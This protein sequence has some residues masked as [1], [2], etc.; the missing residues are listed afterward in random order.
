M[1]ENQLVKVAIKT[2]NDLKLFLFKNYM[3]QIENFFGDNRKAL[4]FLSS[5]MSAVQKVPE[6]LN[7]EGATLVNAFMTMA[8]LGLMPSDVSGE[9]YVLPYAGKAQFQLGYQGLITLFYRAGGQSIRADIV[10]KNDK[11]S[12]ENGQIKH[13]IDI[14]QS[15]KERG[16]AIGAYA[17]ATVGNQEIAKAMN[18]VDII[19]IG[20]K[21]SKSYNTKYTPWKEEN[22]PELMMWKKTV[23]KQLGKLLPKNETINRAIALDNQDSVIADRLKP[24]L[25]ASES[26]KMG[27]LVKENNQ[28]E[29]TAAEN[30]KDDFVAEVEELQKKS[31]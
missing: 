15:N 17:I 9:A 19:N 7:C 30:P 12:Y 10:R 24:A 26:M 21:F 27:E 14:F 8:Q 16:E 22:D 4:K 11:F 31:K 3:N 18:K 5:V 6:L 28:K 29:L 13:T 23:L 1:T 20:A 2:D 25:D